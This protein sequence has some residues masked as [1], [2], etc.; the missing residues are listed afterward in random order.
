MSA[1]LPRRELKAD[2][3][4]ASV[5]ILLATT[6]LQRAVGFG[7]GILFCRWLDPGTLGEWEMAYSFLLTA[8]PLAVLGVPGSFGRYTEHYRQ[9]G[10]LQTFLRRTATWTAICGFGSVAAVG[11]FAPSM[12]NLVFGDTSFSN[13][14][15]GASACLA[16]VI[17]CH[18]LTSLLAGLRLYRAVSALNFIQ[19]VVFAVVS[20]G[21]MWR[22]PTVE[23]VLI[24]YGASCIAASVCGFVWL[25]PAIVGDRPS[26]ERLGHSQFWSKLL[27]FAFFIWVTNCLSNLFAIIDRYMLVHC[28]GMSAA[29]ALAKVGDYHSSRVIPL[30]LISVADLLSGMVMP[31]LSHD[32]ELGRRDQ[33]SHRLNL[34]L[35]LTSLGMLA[36]GACILAAGPFLFHVVLQGKYNGGLEVL[37]WTLAGCLWFGIYSIAQNY[38]WCAERATLNVYP[39]VIG[40]ATNIALNF[41]LLP[42]MGLQGAVLAT[43][44]STAL[45]LAL[46]LLI[47][48]RHGM[49]VDPGTWLTAAAP[50][51]AGFGTSVAIVGV[52]ALAAAALAT[53]WILTSSERDELIQTA[54]SSWQSFTRRLSRN[55]IPA[56]GQAST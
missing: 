11:L 29:E 31:H 54:R 33:V 26:A 44:I 48:Q 20:L 1:E 51:V 42:S 8:A 50:M 36:V 27:R 17:L 13:L 16:A 3:F 10:H 7:R 22:S 38:L 15:I 43:A 32:W 18:T 6:V 4:A 24:G 19:S 47:S 34:T 53:G 28:A 37:P 12:A 23:A 9:R 52:L 21:L 39:L 40:L 46:V 25:W 14:M 5:I 41:I 45:A 30:L 35:K 56:A 49:R 2:T 55:R